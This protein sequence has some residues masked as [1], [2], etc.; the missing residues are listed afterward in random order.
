MGE[1]STFPKTSSEI[2]HSPDIHCTPI[3]L[4]PSA[5]PV[6]QN[7][8]CSDKCFEWGM[9]LPASSSWIQQWW[10][11]TAMSG[12]AKER[13]ACPYE[14][15]WIPVQKVRQTYQNLLQVLCDKKKN[16]V[17]IYLGWTCHPRERH[18]RWQ[19][20]QLS[21]L[22]KS[23]TMNARKTSVRDSFGQ[24]FEAFNFRGTTEITVEWT[25]L[26]VSA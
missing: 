10:I 24:N 20:P 8:F 5:Q 21:I 12:E 9:F 17:R 19:W 4:L 18:F 6:T 2:M 11:D 22:D 16:T 15:K 3:P 14:T 23:D 7:N 1:P 26:Q 13:S 25:K